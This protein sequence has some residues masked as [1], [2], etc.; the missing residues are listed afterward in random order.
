MNRYKEQ[1]VVYKDIK[2]DGGRMVI[3]Q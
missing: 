3:S 2:E 1:G